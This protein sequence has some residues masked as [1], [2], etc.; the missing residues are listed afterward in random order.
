MYL[1]Y[2][3]FILLSA[4]FTS[5][6]IKNYLPGT[7]PATVSAILPLL[8]SSYIHIPFGLC[9]SSSSCTF[10]PFLIPSTLQTHSSLRRVEQEIWTR[11]AISLVVSLWLRRTILLE[12][13]SWMLISCWQ[14]ASAVLIES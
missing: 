14:K 6:L 3:S 2:F 7:I 4:W 8:F 9:Y 5:V 1:S 13:L 11:L 12:A 10:F